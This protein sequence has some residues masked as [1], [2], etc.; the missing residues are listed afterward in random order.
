MIIIS[1][2]TKYANGIEE[3]AVDGYHHLTPPLF[4]PLPPRGKLDTFY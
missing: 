3:W 1:E 4:L 2:P